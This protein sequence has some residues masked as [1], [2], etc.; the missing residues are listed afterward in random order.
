VWKI[1]KNIDCKIIA[2]ELK[3]RA[4]FILCKIGSA[5]FKSSWLKTFALHKLEAFDVV[6][7]NWNEN[8][9]KNENLKNLYFH[10]LK[11]HQVG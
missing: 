4:L 9:Q 10:P 7:E 6:L 2:F 11:G 5:N 3:K 8:L 1:F